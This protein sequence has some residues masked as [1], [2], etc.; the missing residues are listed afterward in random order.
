MYKII[1]SWHAPYNGN[2][3]AYVKHTDMDLHCEVEGSDHWESLTRGC[4]PVAPFDKTSSWPD[5]LAQP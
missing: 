1:Q 4:Y 5:G 3:V 2:V